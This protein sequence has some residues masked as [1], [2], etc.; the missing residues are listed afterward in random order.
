MYSLF[1][2]HIISMP[3]LPYCALASNPLKTINESTKTEP[4]QLI[5]QAKEL[6]V[7]YLTNFF[8]TTHDNINIIVTTVR[9]ASSIFP[10]LD[11]T[12][13]I[14]NKNSLLKYIPIQLSKGLKGIQ[15]GKQISLSKK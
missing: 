11:V 8:M 4:N 12:L 14:Y 9:L 15:N 1:N 6:L 2:K 5:S 10:L 13:L 7:K 3:I